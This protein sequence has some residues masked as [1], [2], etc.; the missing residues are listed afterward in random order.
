MAIFK[1]SLGNTYP[2]DPGSGLSHGEQHHAK[3]TTKKTGKKRARKH[4]LNGVTK[5]TSKYHRYRMTRGKPLGPGVQGSK[6]GK[7][8]VRN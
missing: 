2:K 5:P 3:P 4:R 1:D 8:K 7:N 6:S